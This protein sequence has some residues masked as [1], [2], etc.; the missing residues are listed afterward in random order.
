MISKIVIKVGQK[1]FE[2]TEQEARALQQ[3]LGKL[4]NEPSFVPMPCYPMPPIII[5]RR[6][7]VPT[8]WRP[9]EITC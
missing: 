9:Y 3:E 5:D 2:F 4:F 8:P 1:E 6:D 7:W